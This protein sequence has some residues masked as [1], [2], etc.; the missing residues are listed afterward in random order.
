M[1]KL[2]ESE[3]QLNNVISKGP[4]ILDIYAEWCKPCQQIKPFFEDLSSKHPNVNFVKADVDI[5]E[6]V[7][8]KF[9]VQAMPMFVFFNNGVKVGSFFGAKQDKLKRVHCCI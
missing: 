7:S 2:I 5:A 8:E 6:D 3:E 9:E 4:T 1:V